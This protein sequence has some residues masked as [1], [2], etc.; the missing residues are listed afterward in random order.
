MD[1]KLAKQLKDAGFPQEGKT[2]YRILMSDSGGDKI[3]DTAHNNPD[4]QPE[5]DDLALPTLE[6]VIEE[7]TYALN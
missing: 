5:E 6:E 3:Y 7:S 4:W 2:F 1:Y